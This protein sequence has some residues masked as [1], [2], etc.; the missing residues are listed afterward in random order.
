MSGDNDYHKLRISTG[1]HRGKVKNIE[2]AWKRFCAKFD[3]PSVDQTTTYAHYMRLPVDE[4]GA[5][6]AA[7]GYIVGAHF[8]DGKRR[9]TNMKKR[10]LI[11]FDLDTV[12]ADQM[13]EIEMG[14]SPI[15][16][17]EHLRHTTRAH[18]PEAPRWRIHLP[19]SRPVNHDEANAITRILAAQL[20]SDPQESVDAVDV[21]SHRYAQVSYMPSR[22]KDQEYRVERN[23]GAILDVDKLLADLILP[24]F[25]GHPS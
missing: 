10:H 16:D 8:E 18:C 22:S 19:I 11:S 7:P 6:K 15:C 23:E 4:K 25:G 14:L 5:K 3:E 17:Y 21:V 2:F 1:K 24:R 9:L 12:T 13:D 20:F